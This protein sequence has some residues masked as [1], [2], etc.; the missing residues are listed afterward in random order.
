MS[1]FLLQALALPHAFDSVGVA[2][3]VAYLAVVLVHAAPFWTGRSADVSP[4]SRKLRMRRLRVGPYLHFLTSKSEPMTRT[5]AA[6]L[7]TCIVLAACSGSVSAPPVP[8]ELFTLQAPTRLENES[9]RIDILSDILAFYPGNIA[10]REYRQRLDYVSPQ[11]PDATENV[12]VNYGYQVTGDS[13]AFNAECN[14]VAAD[15]APGP[16]LWGRVTAEGL[17][18][19]VPFDPDAVLRYRRVP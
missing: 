2:F 4:L 18:L 11:T 14:D 17:E 13:I 3:G 12:E 8:S 1:A 6:F 5:P 19:H 9:L 15:C 10:R 16:H 7:L